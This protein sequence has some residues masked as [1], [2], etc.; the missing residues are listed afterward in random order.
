[1][2]INNH[3][4]TDLQEYLGTYVSDES[5]RLVFQEGLLVQAVRKGHWIVLDE[6]NLAPTEVLEALNRCVCSTHRTLPRAHSLFPTCWASASCALSHLACRLLDDNRELYV[7][8]LQ[9]VVR[10]HPHFMLFATQN[11]PGIYAG[12]KTLSRRA[13]RSQWA[14]RSFSSV[15]PRVLP[16]RSTRVACCVAEPFAPASL[17]CT[18]TISLMPSCPPSWKSGGRQPAAGRR[19][20]APTLRSPA[21]PPPKGVALGSCLAC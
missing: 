19:N 20:G 17:S 14:A 13:C 12:R 1:M 7:P 10:P 21:A 6:L 5:G 9:E 4:Q 16:L 2:R 15:V 8:E 18:W 11:P 3:E